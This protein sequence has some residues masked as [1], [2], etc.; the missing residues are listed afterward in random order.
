MFKGNCM[1]RKISILGIVTLRKKCQ[2]SELFWSAF[3]RIWTEYGEIRS[4]SPYSV[5]I[6][7]NTEQNNS[8]YRH[9]LRIVKQKNTFYEH[10]TQNSQNFHH[11]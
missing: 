6:R 3:P 1:N 5:R 9:F 11:S 4:I 10:G 8:K 7:E 2:Y